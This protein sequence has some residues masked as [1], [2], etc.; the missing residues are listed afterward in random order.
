L[1]EWADFWRYQIGVN[2]IPANTREKRTWIPWSKYQD[3]PIPEEQ[4]E[5][6]K[7]GNSF[8]D[9]MAIIPGKVWHNMAKKRL[10]LI[11]V[12]LDNQKAIDEFCIRDGVTTPLMELPKRMIIEQHKDDLTRAHVYCYSTYPFVKKSSDLVK[13]SDS[14]AFEVKGSGEHGI[15]YCCPSPHKNGSKYEIIDTLEPETLDVL[16]G[17]IDSICKKYGIP[18]L[19]NGHGNNSQIPLEELHKP[20]TIIY[21]GHNRHLQLLRKME[22]LIQRNRFEDHQDIKP[23]ARKWNEKHCKPPLTESD[24]ERQ[25]KAGVKFIESKSQVNSKLKQRA[26]GGNGHGEL[27][28]NQSGSDDDSIKITSDKKSGK[29]KKQKLE[30]DDV[31]NEKT[32]REF[33]SFKYSNRG[34]GDLHEAIILSG[35]PV[36]VKYVGDEIELVES[37]EENSRVIKPPEAEEYQYEPYEFTNTEELEQFVNKAKSTT[38]DSFFATAKH[39]VKKYNDQD[40]QIITLLAADVVWSYFQD[41]FPTTHY[42]DVVGDNDTGKSSIGYT[43]EY[44]GYRPVK[45]TAISAANY[46]RTLGMIEPGQCTII[47]DEGDRID[48][49]IEKMAILKTGYELMAKVPKINMNTFDQ[50]PKW[51]YTYCLKIIIAERSLDHYKAKGLMDRTFILHC[52]PGR[53]KGYSIKQIISNYAG[54]GSNARRKSFYQEFA[55]FR[56]T[57]LCCRLVHYNEPIIDIETGLKNRDDELCRPLLQLFHGT[58]AISEI[59]D[60]LGKFVNERKERKSNSVEAALY[61][62]LVGLISEYGYELSV[63]LIWSSIMLKLEGTFREDKPN[64]Y[65]THDYGMMY[66]NTI[67]KMMVDKFG[68]GRKKRKDGNVI[69]F[70]K[71]KLS[72]FVNAYDTSV[73]IQVNLLKDDDGCNGSN[74]GIAGCECVSN[75]NIVQEHESEG[76]ELAT[77]MTLNELKVDNISQQNG[78]FHTEPLDRKDGEI[79]SHNLEPPLPP[80]L[81]PNQTEIIIDTNESGDSGGIVG[82]FG[83]TILHP[84][85]KEIQM[86]IQ[87]SPLHPTVPS[88]NNPGH[89]PTIYRTSQGSDLW[90]CHDCNTPR[91]DI[92]FMRNHQCKKNRKK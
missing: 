44:L 62:I 32:K 20:D 6:W 79:Q 61:P 80:S 57:I 65:E 34:K 2:V 85:T 12:D 81:P 30:D 71:E 17:D 52:K 67:T 7:E 16:E 45:G 23:L 3:D 55:D 68:S 39:L 27:V 47:E 15:A 31:K 5:Q 9:G 53:I 56:K 82:I 74:G 21:E 72:R 29:K 50:K 48:E 25:W 87:E 33:T 49:D 54:G 63:G 90:A 76:D 70:N 41:L 78:V 1:N 73:N 58:K 14:P 4:H 35:I 77:K 10:Y 40:S 13:S 92:W 24:F 59:V 28:S 84:A 69:I 83:E 51:Y 43:F 66:K 60:I 75:D 42:L 46:Y 37:I 86:P 91:G 88:Q 26:D 8:K 64:Q 36:F 22:S 38:L 11:F 19:S 18:Y 89:T